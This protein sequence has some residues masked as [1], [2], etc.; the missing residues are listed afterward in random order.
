MD[1]Y[2]RRR[3]RLIEIRDQLC[4][5][6]AA[7]LAKR[8]SKTDSYVSRML[9]PEGK[10]GRKRIG[11]DMVEQ[12][13]RGFG[14]EPGAFD[15]DASIADL[16]KSA[17]PVSSPVSQQKVPLPSSQTIALQRSLHD[18]NVESGPESKG[19]YPLLSWV[20]AGAW[21]Q[22]VDSFA[23]G[24]A[25]EW[26]DSPF[27]VSGK[28]F[29]LRVRGESM[30]DPANH[31]SFR[32]GEAVLVDPC[33]DARSGSFVVVRLDDEAEATFKQLVIEGE[34]KFLKALNPSWPNRIIQVNGNATICGVVRTKMTQYA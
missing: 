33:T 1:K 32:D 24:D 5:G 23:P 2:E 13:E 12:I 31:E 19:R 11:E 21:E 34:K 8:I 6:A 29:W 25:E 15:S 20:Q 22:I 28:S 3:L 4:D 9:Y 27:K 17:A 7:T 10:S 16:A 26:L 30:F 14:W 18:R